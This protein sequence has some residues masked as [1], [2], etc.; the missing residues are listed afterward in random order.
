MNLDATT[1]QAIR[2]MASYYSTPIGTAPL[3]SEYNQGET[4]EVAIGA[5]Q[6]AAGLVEMFSI[7]WGHP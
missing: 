1:A 4:L 2:A 3:I 5:A 7:F 6:T